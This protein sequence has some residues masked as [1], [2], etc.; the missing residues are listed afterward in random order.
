MLRQLFPVK[1]WKWHKNVER[2]PPL[3][4]LKS[5]PVHWHKYQVSSRRAALRGLR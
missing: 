3:A 5:R 2:L 1:S 4:S